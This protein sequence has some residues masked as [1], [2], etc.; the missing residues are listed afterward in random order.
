[1]TSM[2]P[3]VIITNIQRA[4]MAIWNNPHWTLSITETHSHLPLRTLEPDT[5]TIVGWITTTLMNV[6]GYGQVR[7]NSDII[8]F[9]CNRPGHRR[10]Q[11][12]MNV[13]R[14]AAMYQINDREA[15]MSNYP[16][17]EPHNCDESRGDG[18]VKLALGACYQS[19]LE[20]WVQMDNS[21]LNSGRHRWYH[22]AEEVSMEQKP[23]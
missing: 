16:Y 10:L 19:Q 21:N 1:M 2:K 12:P 3:Q 5:V 4:Q 13:N 11:C 9:K 18:E 6:G 22:V 20:H 7:T 17:G 23:L 14:M 8:C 15:A